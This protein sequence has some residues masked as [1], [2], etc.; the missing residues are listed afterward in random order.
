VRP[1]ERGGIKFAIMGLLKETIEEM[2]GAVR[3]T[4]GDADKRNEIRE[5]LEEAAKKVGDI[6]KR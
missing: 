3:T 1:F 4:A 5:V 2:M 6:A